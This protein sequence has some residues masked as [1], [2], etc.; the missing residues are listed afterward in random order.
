MAGAGPP[1]HSVPPSLFLA[2]PEGH[3]SEQG[4]CRHRTRAS[5]LQGW[6][7]A[8]SQISRPTLHGKAPRSCPSAP[9]QHSARPFPQPAPPWPLSGAVHVS[10][11]PEAGGSVT[12][13]LTAAD[14]ACRS[15]SQDFVACL[16]FP[17]PPPRPCW[18]RRPSV[19]APW[20]PSI[21]HTP[22]H[23]PQD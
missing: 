4:G 20:G 16:Q 15:L 1:G 5:G 17:G 23:H 12:C 6:D 21:P 22:R 10:M 13:F 14:T 18:A 11:S 8:W 2:W 3:T 7:V 19:T 9:A